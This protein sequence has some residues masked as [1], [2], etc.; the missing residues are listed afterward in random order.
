MFQSIVEG[1]AI[2]RSLLTKDVPPDKHHDLDFLVG[3]LEWEANVD[4]EFAKHNRVFPIPAQ[5]FDGDRAAGIS[6]SSGCVTARAGT[7]RRN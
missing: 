5:P 2:D 7:R 6:R 1:R 4:Q 3:L